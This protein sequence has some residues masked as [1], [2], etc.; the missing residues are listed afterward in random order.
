MSVRLHTCFIFTNTVQYTG[1]VVRPGQ[2]HVSS[3]TSMQ[4][5]A[6]N[7]L[8]LLQTFGPFSAMKCIPPVRQGFPYKIAAPLNAKL[9]KGQPDKFAE[10]SDE[11]TTTFETL[12]AKLA[13]PPVLVLPCGH[14]K[15]FVDTN[16]NDRQV[17]FVLLQV[18]PD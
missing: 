5:K 4:Y 3:K 14:R 7:H 9:R 16:T 11:D 15:L 1:H 13:S 8:I 6:L 18:Q 12:K 17:G 2:L 10:V